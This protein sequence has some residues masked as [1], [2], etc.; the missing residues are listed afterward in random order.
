MTSRW[1]RTTPVQPLPSNSEGYSER[2]YFWIGWA[3]GM[4]SAVVLFLVFRLTAWL[5]GPI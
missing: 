2:G 5:I 1:D 4:A 3:V